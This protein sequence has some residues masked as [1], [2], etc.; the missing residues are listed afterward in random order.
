[1]AKLIVALAM[2]LDG[3][4]A[5]SNDGADLPLGAGGM[6]L[7]QWYFN[8]DTPSRTYAAA[9]ARGVRVP[10]FKLSSTSAQVF[11]ALLENTGAAITGRRTYD[12]AGGWGGNGLVPGLPLFVLTHHAPTDVPK[13][14]S[15]YT[16]V[17]DGLESAVAQ[18][19]AAAGDKDVRLTGASV[20]QQCLRAG[21]LD[22]I[23]IHLVPVLLASG[24]RLFEH[25][26][27]ERIDLE[28]ISV[29]DSPGVTHLRY[30]VVK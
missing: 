21:L 12:I 4:I 8:G 14:E 20:P 25:L 6:R 13:G 7:L 1:M 2:S 18:A 15:Q 27:A 17:T 28:T 19:K 11:D 9:A 30:G 10:P 26:G 16:F 24:V 3:F 22:E 29:V 5:G 23:Q